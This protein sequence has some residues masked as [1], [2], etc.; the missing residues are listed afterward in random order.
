[1]SIPGKLVIAL[2]AAI[3]VAYAASVIHPELVLLQIFGIAFISS[4][5]AVILS[6]K[7]LSPPAALAGATTSARS[8]SSPVQKASDVR[9]TKPQK[10]KQRRERERESKKK[11]DNRDSVDT[12]AQSKASA[13]PA[14]PRESGTVKWFNGTKG[15]GFIV[16]DSGEEIFVHYRSILGEGRRGLRDGQSVTYRVEETDKG[17]QAEDVE[18]LD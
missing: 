17:P 4:A 10:S 18:G 15:F 7:P 12:P 8:S 1:M 2:L 9:D 5:A 14:G 3:V 13:A 11:S 16:R 6:H